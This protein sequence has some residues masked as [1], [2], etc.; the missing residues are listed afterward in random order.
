MFFALI[1]KRGLPGVYGDIPRLTS[2]VAEKFSFD[3]DVAEEFANWF[4]NDAYELVGGAVDF[5]EIDMY[6]TD[7]CARLIPWLDVQ[8]QRSDMPDDIR[9]LF[10]KLREFA[11]R[12]VELGTGVVIEL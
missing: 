11:G 7:Q 5:F 1:L 12:A 9:R 8:I 6:D 10:V 2:D 3:Y 4:A